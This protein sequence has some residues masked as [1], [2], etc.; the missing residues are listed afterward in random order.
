MLNETENRDPQRHWGR[1]L[2]SNFPLDFTRS[3]IRGRHEQSLAREMSKVRAVQLELLDSFGEPDDPQPDFKRSYVMIE[4]QSEVSEDLIPFRRAVIFSDTVMFEALCGGWSVESRRI[5]SI[6]FGRGPSRTSRALAV[7]LNSELVSRNHFEIDFA[8][9]FAPCSSRIAPL[10]LSFPLLRAP[11]IILRLTEFAGKTETPPLI[12]RELGSLSGTWLEL[13]DTPLILR[14]GARI[15][16]ERGLQLEASMA[17]RAIPGRLIRQR[18]G[19]GS[20]F[21]FLDPRSLPSVRADMARLTS[22]VSGVFYLRLAGA[23]GPDFGGQEFGAD[24]SGAQIV[25][26]SPVPTRSA[27]K[28]VMY[29]LDGKKEFSL[30]VLK[31]WEGDA[32]NH[33]FM[34]LVEGNRNCL[35]DFG[36]FKIGFEAEDYFLA[37]GDC[38]EFEK[39]ERAWVATGVAED[40]RFL[41]AEKLIPRETNVLVSDS[42]LRIVARKI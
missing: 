16:F 17:C 31:S 9:L 19:G 32:K 42:V 37:R 40:G 8:N 25:R 28:I 6:R 7:T 29:F 36:K 33:S 35:F 34:F 39:A 2:L 30:L 21:A 14:V 20:D 5:T 12:L 23:A 41:P 15:N 26:V 1:S 38:E 24:P 13:A 22:Q 18:R 4:N 10:L 11:K 3:H 27:E